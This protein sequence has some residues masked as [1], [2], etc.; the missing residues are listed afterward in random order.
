MK[1][2]LFLLIICVFLYN[3]KS[4]KYIQVFETI[5]TDLKTENRAHVFENDTLKIT[6]DFWDAYGSLNFKIFNKLDRPIFV[7]TDKSFFQFTNRKAMYSQDLKYVSYRGNNI[8]DTRNE[9]RLEVQSDDKKLI[10]ISSKS[11]YTYSKFKILFISNGL[12]L[13]KNNGNR[14][15]NSEIGIQ[16]SV[17]IHKENIHPSSLTFSN[18]LVFCFSETF[19][20]EFTIKN[21]F[22]ISQVQEMKAENFNSKG[23]DDTGKI[24]DQPNNLFYSPT[25]FYLQID[26]KYSVDRK[27]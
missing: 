9:K 22:Y 1:K 11:Y 21:E 15:P 10:K 12:L 8:I 24:V 4:S 18:N 2:F 16:Q 3:C 20:E 5:G 7:D 25:R 27:L 13:S 19:R 26:K 23:F 14:I 6:Y 17:P